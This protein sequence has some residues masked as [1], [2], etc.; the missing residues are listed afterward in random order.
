MILTAES[1]VG[2]IGSSFADDVRSGLE[3]PGQKELPS[4]HLYDAVGSALFDTICLLPEYGLARAGERLLRRHAEDIVAHLLGPVV[5]AELG[6]GS[7]R[8][9]RWLVEAILRRQSLTYHPI[10]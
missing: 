3:R 10:D 8:N 5:V 4:K 6:S 1:R 9:T 2:S 7:A